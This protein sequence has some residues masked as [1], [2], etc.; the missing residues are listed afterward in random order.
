M[1]MHFSQQNNNNSDY[2]VFLIMDLHA[3]TAEKTLKIK[4]FQSAVTATLF[5]YAHYLYFPE[6]KH[7]Q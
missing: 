3:S 2:P 6:Q 4:V 7:Q 1:K 5:I